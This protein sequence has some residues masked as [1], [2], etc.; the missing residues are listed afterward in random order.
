MEK[1]TGSEFFDMYEDKLWQGEKDHWHMRGRDVPYIISRPEGLS[2]EE[3][4]SLAELIG[5]GDCGK[6]IAACLL[7]EEVAGAKAL[8]EASAKGLV[9]KS[10]G[11]W[12]APSRDRLITLA[13]AMGMDCKKT[14]DLLK[15]AGFDRLY[16]R[17]GR[18]AGLIFAINNGMSLDE[19]LRDIAPISAK[20]DGGEWENI[21]YVGQLRDYVR[22]RRNMAASAITL[23]LTAQVSE[24]LYALRGDAGVFENWLSENSL[25]VSGRERVRFYLCRSLLGAID[26]Q[27][28][29]FLARREELAK[30]GGPYDRTA[31]AETLPK[32]V[33]GTGRQKG[34]SLRFSTQTKGKF[35]ALTGESLDDYKINYTW[36]CREMLYF[37]G[38]DDLEE[39][40]I[41]AYSGRGTSPESLQRLFA[42]HLSPG[43]GS[44][45]RIILFL[46]SISGCRMSFARLDGMMRRCGF[47]GPD[48]LNVDDRFLLQMMLHDNYDDRQEFVGTFMDELSESR[49]SYPAF[50]LLVGV[51]RAYPEIFD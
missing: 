50:R 49:M 7:R 44:I 2:D 6:I 21:T 45:M 33:F 46:D 32:L 19:W 35:D 11:A 5:G 48:S 43:R 18:D 40:D 34:E 30:K 17:D 15:L 10:G 25:V 12:S 41:G 8:L 47:A 23:D 20:Y 37:Y 51:N 3:F 42:G 1:C 24:E 29:E 13:F 26:S 9:R 28:E 16:P 31:A 22:S 27:I 4:R 38:G 36:L 39:G 14:G